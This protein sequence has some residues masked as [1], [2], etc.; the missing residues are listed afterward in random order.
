MGKA[1]EMIEALDVTRSDLIHKIRISRDEATSKLDEIQKQN[2][3]LE[4]RLKRMD[5]IVR[6]KAKISLEN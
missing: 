2:T 4:P 3:S 5:D 1:K 6:L